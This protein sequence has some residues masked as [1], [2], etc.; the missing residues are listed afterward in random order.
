MQAMA[1]QLLLIVC[2]HK[3]VKLATFCHYGGKEKQTDIGS[4]HI[5]IQDEGC[6]QVRIPVNLSSQSGNMLTL[7]GIAER[8]V[9]GL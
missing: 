3:V 2:R 6:S 4:A 9:F 5:C 1:P 8:F 7:T